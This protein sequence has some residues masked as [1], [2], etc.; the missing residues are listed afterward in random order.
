MGTAIAT[1]ISSI[2]FSFMHYSQGSFTVVAYDI[3]TIFIDSLIYSVIYH[4]TK[5]IFASWIAHYL[6][7]IFGVVAMIILF[8]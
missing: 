3:F 2:V 4:R 7:D 8:K 5:N 1:I 6:A